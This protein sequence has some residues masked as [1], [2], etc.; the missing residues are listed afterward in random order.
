MPAEEFRA[1]ADF[2]GWSTEQIMV[3]LGVS[4]NTVST[5]RRD[6]ADEQ[7]RLACRSIA[8]AEQKVEW[9]VSYPWERVV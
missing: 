8:V 6:G 4:R 2:M 3:G 1:W 9:A 7:T 5:Y